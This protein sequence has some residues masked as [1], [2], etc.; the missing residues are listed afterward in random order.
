M[1]NVHKKENIFRALFRILTDQS[2]KT[3]YE[4]WKEGKRVFKAPYVI[5]YY[6]NITDFNQYL[7]ARKMNKIGTAIM[8]PLV[9]G[10]GI[11]LGYLL[12]G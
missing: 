9:F 5:E 2:R 7:K 3:P 10:C 1:D 11:W 12:W 6:K 8:I 4:N